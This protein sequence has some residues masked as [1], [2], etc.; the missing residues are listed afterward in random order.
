M[1]RYFINRNHVIPADYD[2]D[3]LLSIYYDFIRIRNVIPTELDIR[4]FFR[5]DFN[6]FRRYKIMHEIEIR[7]PCRSSVEQFRA[8]AADSIDDL[9]LCDKKA[10]GFAVKGE[11]IKNCTKTC[12]ICL[13]SGK[14][15]VKIELD[16]CGCIFHEDCIRLSTKYSSLCPLCYQGINKQE[17]QEN[18]KKEKTEKGKSRL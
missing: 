17:E 5:N 11:T 2:H 14:N 1:T 16:S 10:S 4:L 13:E 12:P 7:V 6:N 8:V 18:A 9:F 3:W 15:K